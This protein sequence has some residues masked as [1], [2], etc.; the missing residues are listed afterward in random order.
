MSGLIVN[1]AHL[2]DESWADSARGGVTW[3]TVF[4]ADRTPTAGMVCGIAQF[5]PGTGLALHHHPEAELYYGL[6][7]SGTVTL[8]DRRVEIAQGMA[9]FIPGKTV[10]GVVAGPQGLT[11]LYVFD[12]DSFDQIR[13]CFVEDGGSRSAA[14]YHQA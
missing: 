11:L 5:E 9:A 8:G 12:A 14:S 1:T 3:R 6:A 7:G 10:H 4:S 2:S 13:Y